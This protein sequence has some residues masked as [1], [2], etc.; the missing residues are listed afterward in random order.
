MKGT[1]LF[2]LIISFCTK[3][4]EDSIGD[5]RFLR[6]PAGSAI[7]AFY[8]LQASSGISRD[9]DSSCSS[10]E[11]KSD[12]ED[13]IDCEGMQKVCPGLTAEDFR[14]TYKRFVLFKKQGVPQAPSFGRHAHL[15]D[16]DKK[17][18]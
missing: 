1:F 8:L 18:W 7:C 6:R 15:G 5:E 11:T 3:A 9:S 14:T 2:L 13:V 16:R 12:L 17:L 10:Q 4:S